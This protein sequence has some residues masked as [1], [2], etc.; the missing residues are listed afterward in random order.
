MNSYAAKAMDEGRTSASWR[1]AVAV[2]TRS[3]IEMLGTAAASAHRCRKCIEV[4][5]APLCDIRLGLRELADERSICEYGN[6]FL[7][8]FHV[9]RGQ[10]HR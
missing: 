6:C 8:A 9:I 4:L 10:D 1:R 3:N 2:I 7:K 5:H